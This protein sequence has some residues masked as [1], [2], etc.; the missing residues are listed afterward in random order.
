M[1][2]WCL[3][4]L[5][6]ILMS[7]AA[8]AAPLIYSAYTITFTKGEWA[9]YTLPENQDVILPNIIISR[10]ESMGIFNIAT[11]EMFEFN[12]SPEGTRWAFPFNNFG[13]T[14]SAANWESLVFE[15]W[16]TANGGPGGGPPA[17]VG[18]DAA[19]HLVEQDLYLD[20]RFTDWG[21]GMDS[22][23]Y[24][25]Y[26]RAAI[27]PSADFDRDG[28]VDGRD[29]LTW[30]RNAGMADPL[31]SDG[32][33]NFDGA[34]NTADLAVWQAAYA[35]PPI[36]A[37]AAVPEPGGLFAAGVGLATLLIGWRK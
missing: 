20:I 36:S 27:T 11:E 14:I 6:I 34:I 23:G 29:F 19:V 7:G 15:D 25:A 10:A 1:R 8:S 3:S 22:G 37:I 33:A 21:I 28:D 5:V 24:F 18:H 13:A 4:L 17:T 9:D 16:Q 31:Q 2:D 12:F 26:E 30:Q 35:N 32:D